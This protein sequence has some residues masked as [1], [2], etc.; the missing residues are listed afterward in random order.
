MK[1]Y[2]SHIILFFSFFIVGKGQTTT[3]FIQKKGEATQLV[4]DNRPFLI[5]GGELENFTGISD[6]TLIDGA[7]ELTCKQNFN[8]KTEK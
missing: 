2:I 6:Y 8:S 5:L 4:I 7:I 3:P 1:I